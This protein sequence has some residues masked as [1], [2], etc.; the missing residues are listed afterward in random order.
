MTGLTAAVVT[1]AP[2]ALSV[3]VPLSVKA[4]VAVKVPPVALAVSVSSPSAVPLAAVTSAPTVELALMA[5]IRPLRI[6]AR[7]A[8]PLTGKVTVL[9]FTMTL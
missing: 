1:L 7:V 9:P 2:A 6:S 3:A 8:R 5:A 4:A